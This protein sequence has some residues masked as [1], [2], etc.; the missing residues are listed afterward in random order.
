M[1]S[2]SPASR[3]SVIWRLIISLRALNLEFLGQQERL[4][5]N[6]NLRAENLERERTKRK[7]TTQIQ[8]QV[9]WHSLDHTILLAVWIP[10]GHDTLANIV[11]PVGHPFDPQKTQQETRMRFWVEAQGSAE[12]ICKGIFVLFGLGNSC[13]PSCHHGSWVF[14]P[15]AELRATC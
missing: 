5:V 7:S 8:F 13:I 2:L 9:R 10:S 12:E 11:S 1:G 14:A 15:A 4:C 6:C 3:Q